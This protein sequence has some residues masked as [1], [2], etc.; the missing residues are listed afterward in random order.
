MRVIRVEV[1][2]LALAALLEAWM[3]RD[4]RA[5]GPIHWRHYSVFLPAGILGLGFVNAFLR[6]KILA[7]SVFTLSLII[8]MIVLGFVAVAYRQ[9][10][11]AAL[12]QSVRGLAL[13]AALGTAG[14]YQLRLRPAPAS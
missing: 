1:I 5:A 13:Y 7:W 3:L 9:L 11:Q 8:F 14:L 2:C 12:G 4:L 6:S 10:P